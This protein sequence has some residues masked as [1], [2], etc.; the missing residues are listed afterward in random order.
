MN[1]WFTSLVFLQIQA[2]PTTCVSCIN[3]QDIYD[4]TDVNSTCSSTTA[5]ADSCQKIRIQLPGT[6]LVSKGCAKNCKANSVIAGSIRLDVTCCTTSNCNKAITIIL[7][8]ILFF[9]S[10]IILIWHLDLVK[11]WNYLLINRIDWTIC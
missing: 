9:I 10:F 4:G 11:I 6:I 8:P 5:N 7:Q 1:E 3:C 2:Q